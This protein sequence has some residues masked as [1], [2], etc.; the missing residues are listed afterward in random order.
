M[1]TTA[2]PASSENLVRGIGVRQ[3]AA[4][5]V[6][7][8]V[9]AG[10]FLMPALVAQGVGAAAPLVFL[11]CG[12]VMALVVTAF[13]IAG[14]RVSVSGGVFAYAEAAFGPYV[15]FVT[16]F[17]LWLSC[18][19][20]AAS[21]AVALL[22]A[23]PL[24]M[25]A[26]AGDAARLG[27]L[28]AML[29]ILALINIRGVVSGARTIEVLTLG[30]LLP[31]A[32]F[33]L[34][35]VFAI[36]P[37][38]LAWPGMPAAPDRGRMVLLAIFAF[39]GIE[40]ALSP[41]GEIKTPS[42]TVP[43]AIYLA[44]ALT[45]TLYIAIQ[46]VAQ[47]VLGDSLADHAEAPL[48]DAAALFMGP[49]GA[50]LVM[51]GALVS[52]LGYVSGD[53]LGTPRTLYAF[54]RDGFLPAAW[55]R[56]H[57]LFRTPHLAIATHA[58]VVFAFAASGTFTFLVIVANVATLSVYLIACLAAIPLLRRDVRADGQGFRVP[59]GVTVPVLAAAAIVGILLSARWQEFAA[60][61]LTV[62]LASA[63]Y[64]ARRQETEDRSWDV[65]P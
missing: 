51:A 3:L 31:L 40:V 18:A 57:P 53:L 39:L 34:L 6:N 35:G 56:V 19:V 61:A 21:V 52:M 43:R 37:A 42:S 41:S 27:L 36:D 2:A 54:G 55:G 16:G 50:T 1:A 20:S 10:I 46:A 11:L 32:A 47:G 59:G 5:I 38:A 25:P 45:T 24:L 26:L 23:A 7:C 22:N 28:A 65:S 63:V 44:L 4:S 62:A 17:L 14:S 58:V 15:G 48:A 9:G 13:A 8:T 29:G 30:K 64:M 33:V 49:V 60:T 12:A